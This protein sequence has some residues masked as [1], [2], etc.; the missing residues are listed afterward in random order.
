MMNG[1]VLAETVMAMEADGK[2]E[3]CVSQGQG[4][5]EGDQSP[6]TQEEEAEQ[7]ETQYI[8]LWANEAD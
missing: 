5:E 1:S 7:L 6:V 8:D 3:M 2:M 4:R